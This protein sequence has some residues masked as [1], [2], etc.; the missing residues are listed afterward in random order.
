MKRKSTIWTPK[1]I[2]FLVKNYANVSNNN[3]SRVLGIS[4]TSIKCKASELGLKKECVKRKIFSNIENQ[5]I[6]LSKDVSYRNIANQMN[7]SLAA[8]P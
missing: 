6:Q 1:N 5:V 2:D 7:I 4:T 3:L 8:V